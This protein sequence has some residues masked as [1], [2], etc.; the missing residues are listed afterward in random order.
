MTVFEVELSTVPGTVNLPYNFFFG[1]DCIAYSLFYSTAR[2]R[3]RRDCI[4]T[5]GTTRHDSVA[6]WRQ[7]GRPRLAQAGR[8]AMSRELHLQR[9]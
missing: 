7:A 9:L 8:I 6:R 3:M 2:S 5:V 4:A 1:E